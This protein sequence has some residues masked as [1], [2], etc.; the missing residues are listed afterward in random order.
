T[1]AA[2]QRGARPAVARRRLGPARGAEPGEA[3]PGEAEPGDA[4]PGRAEPGKA[5]HP[6]PDQ[7][8]RTADPQDVVSDVADPQQRGQAEGGGQGPERQAGRRGT[9]RAPPAPE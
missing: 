2:G 3:E 8:R 4:E 7:V 6:E 5:G 9:R 1:G